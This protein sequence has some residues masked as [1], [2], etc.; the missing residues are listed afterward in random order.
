MLRRPILQLSTRRLV[1]KIPVQITS[2][3]PSYLSSRKPFSATSQQPKGA[4]GKQSDSGNPYGNVFGGALL[5]GSFAFAAYHYASKEPLKS[6]HNPY[7]PVNSSQSSVEGDPE[8]GLISEPTVQ[9]SNLLTSNLEHSE[10]D[11]STHPYLDKKEDVNKN[12]FDTQFQVGDTPELAQDDLNEIHEEGVDSSSKFTEVSNEAA[13][14]SSS[15]A[16]ETSDTESLATNYS[17]G[18]PEAVEGLPTDM[19]DTS[20]PITHGIDI[21]HAQDMAK[22]DASGETISLLDDYYLRDSSRETLSANKDLDDAMKDLNDA[23]I[24]KDGKLLLDF[25]DAIHEAEKRQADVDA[26]R[27][28]EEKRIMKEKYEKELKDTRAREL[29]YAEREV[30]LEKELDR[31]KAKAAVA[32]K[33]LQE[34]LEEKHKIELEEKETAAELKF[35]KVQELAKAELNAAI[36]SEKASQIEKMAEANVHINAL[37]MA[38][39]ARSEETRQSHSAHKLALGALALE[40]S[41]SKGLPIQKEIEAL[42]TYLEG[43]DKDSLLDLVLSSLPEET[44]THGTD[45]LLKL[46]HKFDELKQTLRHFSFIPPGGGGILSHSLA[47]VASRLKVKEADQ[48][49]DGIEALINRVEAF[50]AQGKLLEAANALEAGVKGSQAAEIVSDWVRHARNRAITEQALTLLQSFATSISLT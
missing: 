8:G 18:Q 6:S 24:A 39:Y 46:N 19:H 43:I 31:E 37:C 13:S 26:R 4:P 23:Y 12:E 30:L 32:L 49:G 50:L 45:T 48:S 17:M 44:R 3:I 16:E 38:F 7:E 34:K 2:Q 20:V 47:H 28:G 10:H 29:M 1:E 36:A 35:R 21:T 25:L 41:L 14:A 15:N 40:D 11:V 27:F 9:E 5:L 33:S 42:H 22:D